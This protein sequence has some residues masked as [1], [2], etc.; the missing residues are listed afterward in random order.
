M[1][2]SEATTTAT[3]PKRTT[4]KDGPKRVFKRTAEKVHD[5]FKLVETTFL[6]NVA[7]QAGVKDYVK[8]GHAHWYHTFS[9]K[10]VAQTTCSH[11]GGHFHLMELV[12]PATG[13]QPAVY[14]CSPPV[15]YAAKKINGAMQKIT[16]PFNDDDQH[17]HD[18]SYVSSQ[19]LQESKTNAE[20]IKYI[21]QLESRVNPPRLAGV[22]G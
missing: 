1:T 8:T 6:K 19:V 16:V 17:T 20:A 18:V 11:Q 7:W 5:L 2:E 4:K 10:G 3:T 14:K 15:K 12:T 9:S 21:S 13:D 22:D